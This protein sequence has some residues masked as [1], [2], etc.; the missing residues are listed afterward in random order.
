MRKRIYAQTGAGFDTGDPYFDQPA[1]DPY[2]DLLKS[3]GAAYLGNSISS[4]AYFD[5]LYPDDKVMAKK[6]SKQSALLSGAI[7]G[8]SALVT[9]YGERQDYKRN[10]KWLADQRADQYYRVP[11][12]R[13]SYNENL[14]NPYNQTAY[15]H[16]G[17]VRYQ[18]GGEVEMEAPDEQVVLDSTFDD[19]QQGYQQ[20]YPEYEAYEDPLPLTPDGMYDLNS[21]VPTLGNSPHRMNISSGDVASTVQQI[22]RHESG[23]DYGAV[24]TLG[25]KAALNAT[26][27]YQFVPKYWHQ[28]IAKFQ[29]TEGKTQAETMEAFRQNPGIQDAFMSHVVSKYYLPE[30]KNL[31]PLAK[32]YGL[33]QNAL[34]K[35][36]HY[37]GIED[38]RDRLRT[39]NFEVSQWEK[40]TYNNPDILSYVR[41]K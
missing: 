37:R 12:D 10:A 28:E 18:D 4:K 16:G 13:Y 17:K 8:A 24:N 38:T 32:Q 25:G 21:F 36:L 14:N 6:K 33:D 27:K 11:Y 20:D 15:K 29:G 7:G 23:G 3:A 31:L 41:G 9:Q 19:S 35:M 5:Y 26:G 39:G 2:A 34:I 1:F 40:K 30:V 22:A